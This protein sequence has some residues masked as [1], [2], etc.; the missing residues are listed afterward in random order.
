MLTPVNIFVS[1]SHDDVELKDRLLEHLAG[2]LNEGLIKV[3][4][5]RQIDAGDY[6]VASIDNHIE[7][8][9]IILLLV[10]P[11][12]LASSYCYGIE[13]KR[14]LDRGATGDTR[15][16]PVIL[17]PAD[18]RN[19]KLG[20]LQALPTGGRAI[21]TW[22][23]LDEAFLDVATGLRSVITRLQTASEGALPL[24]QGDNSRSA[25]RGLARYYLY[26]SDSKIN[27]LFPQVPRD[28]REEVATDLGVPMDESRNSSPANSDTERIYR[29]ETVVRFIR[30]NRVV[31]S[32]DRPK[33]YIAGTHDLLWGNLH[34][35]PGSLGSLVFFTGQIDTTT[36]L[37][38]G[39]S[40]HLIGS[41]KPEESG[42]SSS[43]VPHIIESIMNEIEIAQR[44]IPAI[45]AAGR[46]PAH[47]EREFPS[48]GNELV[49]A[50]VHQAH[51]HITGASQNLDFLARTLLQ[52][53]S[54]NS[55][56]RCVL[57]SPLYVSLAF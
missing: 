35:S 31:G 45:T 5:D 23:N 10:S 22:P 29:L 14:A 49:L 33:E 13:L 42:F 1:Y 2:L 12:F 28:L 15:V 36:L 25:Q 27:M 43:S 52:G 46:I 24:Q 34:S 48:G 44:P 32:L 39:S 38:C 26:I 51:S 37:M 7:V 21:T 40:R 20:G 9:A 3:W 53:P 11:S 50:L 6:W 30:D 57:A 17:R 4:H 54:P 55:K 56:G 19:S 8:S 16:I 41:L 18:W 47:E